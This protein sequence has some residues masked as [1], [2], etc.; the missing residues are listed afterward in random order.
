MTLLGCTLTKIQNLFNTVN[1]ELLEVSDW[2][3]A[4]KL[5]LNN[6]KTNHIIFRP[7]Q[8][9]IHPSVDI[10]MIDNKTQLPTPIESKTYVKFH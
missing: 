9:K 5:S 8:S 7:Y 10:H 4:N 3:N 2:L 1:S 6:K